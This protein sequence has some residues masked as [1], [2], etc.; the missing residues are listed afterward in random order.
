ML[1]RYETVSGMVQRLQKFS[2]SIGSACS[3]TLVTAVLWRRL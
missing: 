3:T 2:D 1:A